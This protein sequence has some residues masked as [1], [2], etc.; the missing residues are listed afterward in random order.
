MEQR[1]REWHLRRMGKFTAS[2]VHNLMTASGKWTQTAISYLYK[3]Q[4]QRTLKQPAPCKNA[5]SLEWGQINEKYAIEWLRENFSENI[6]WCD[7]DGDEKV[8]IDGFDGFGGSPDAYL[9]RPDNIKA[10]IE[11]KSVFGETET[12]YIFSPTVPLS[13]KREFVFKEHGDQLAAQMLL[14]NAPRVIYL[15]KY[16]PMDENDEFDVRSPLSPD[17]GIMFQFAKEELLPKMKVIEERVKFANAYLN[18]GMDIDEI[19]KAWEEFKK[20]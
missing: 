9:G 16:D 8:F 18:S 1:E 11:I 7:S 17:R 10:F 20:L 2:E 6:F 15:M 5:R 4:R 12:N 19:Q 14:P 3:I 13:K